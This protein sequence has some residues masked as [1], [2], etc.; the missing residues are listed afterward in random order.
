[1]KK[2]ISLVLALAMVLMAVGAFADDPA[3]AGSVDTSISISGLQVGDTVKFYQVLEYNDAADTTGGWV[4]TTGFNA[5]SPDNLNQI[6]GL[7][8]YAVGKTKANEAGITAELAGK[9]AAKA[10]GEATYTLANITDTTATKGKPAAGLYVAIIT[11]AAGTDVTYNPVFVGADYYTNTSGT[12]A[13]TTDMSYS[14]EAMA[15]KAIVT[16]EKTGVDTT[17]SVDTNNEETVAV[18]D[19]ITFTVNTVIPGFAENYTAPVFKLSD[20]LSAGLTYQND[21]KVTVPAGLL[22]GTQWDFEE[23]SDYNFVLAFKAEYLKTVTTPT[24]VTVTYTAIVNSNAVKSV[25]PE[26]NTITLNYSNSPDDTEGHGIKKDKTN[27]YS[28]DIDAE[29]FG[30]E[31]YDATEVVKVGVDKDGKEITQTIQLDNQHWV[32]ALSGAEFKLF[33]DNNGAKGAAYTNRFYTA[34]SVF[35]SDNN[36]RLKLKGSD[37]QGIRGLD[38]GTYW[39]E[40]TKAPD[41]YIKLQ[42]A[43]KIEII[44]VTEEKTYT[45]VVGGITVTYKADELVSYSIKIGGKET[46][47]YRMENVDSGTH[48]HL[49]TNKGDTVVGGSDSQDGKPSDNKDGKLQNTQGVEL[50]STGGMGT[51]IFYIVGGL[52]LVGA[53]IVLISRRKAN[54]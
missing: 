29:L 52:L 48:P 10:T 22:K 12:W 44:A 15:K 25:N 40:E 6:L 31:N 17:G 7:G 54:D 5:L 41:G 34:D 43:V 46:A 49:K 23:S 18:G 4:F 9:I 36:G 50:P 53:A 13:V 30:E 28:F 35:V 47:N 39:L 42:D 3:W 51:T 2:L 21:A 45:E 20:K 1:M 24:N 14:D 38:A 8:D 33:E 27:H 19:T 32:G 37:V 16:L 26:D 11:P